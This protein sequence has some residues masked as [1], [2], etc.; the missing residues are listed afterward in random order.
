M[1]SMASF[2]PAAREWFAAAFPA[3]ESTLILAPTGSG[4]TL[5][6]FLSA[7]S[8][9]AFSEPPPR[10]ERCRVVYVSPLKALAVDV[11]KN[12]RVPIAGLAQAA[13]RR[14]DAFHEALV[15]IRSGDT[16]QDARSRMLRRPPDILVTTPESLCLML[17]S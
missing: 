2:H 9:L 12:L 10:H 11:E 13:S 1:P 8:R 6:A 3:G 15:A 5:A 14:G 7:L 4:K 16:P 17:T